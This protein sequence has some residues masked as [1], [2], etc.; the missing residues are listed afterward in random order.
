MPRVTQHAQQDFPPY[1]Q[2]S[3]PNRGAA[4]RGAASNRSPAHWPVYGRL[5]CRGCQNRR[6]SCCLGAQGCRGSCFPRPAWGDPGLGAHCCRHAHC[7]DRIGLDKAELG[8]VQRLHIALDRGLST[9]TSLQFWIWTLPPTETAPKFV[10][11]VPLSISS[12]AFVWTSTRRRSG[13][14]ATRRWRKPDS[15]HRY[16]RTPP[17]SRE[18]SS[19][20]CLIPRHWK[21]RRESPRKLAMI[22]S[23]G[24]EPWC[25]PA[26]GQQRTNEPAIEGEC[27]RARLAVV[28]AGIGGLDPPWHSARLE[29]VEG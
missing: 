15:N 26:A 20:L 13:S 25:S 24:R 12:P 10:T 28:G 21:S 8:I 27:P 22:R 18:G 7:P 11:I 14:Q 29:G 5:P 9:S 1:Y 19:R 16:R 6:R 17:R 4:A 2:S 23:R 3:A